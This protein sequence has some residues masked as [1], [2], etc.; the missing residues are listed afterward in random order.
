M[1]NSDLFKKFEIESKTHSS[2]VG[3][4]V[5]SVDTDTNN[6]GGHDVLES[7]NDNEGNYIGLDTVS[8]G[9]GDKDKPDIESQSLYFK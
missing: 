3:G 5:T 2:I 4:F 6:T 7:S 8:T 9:P 1:N